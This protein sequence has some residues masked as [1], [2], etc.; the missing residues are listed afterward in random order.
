MSITVNIV[1]PEWVATPREPN[2]A[3]EPRTQDRWD[4]GDASPSN[5]DGEEAN[6]IRACFGQEYLAAGLA[7]DPQDGA[8]QPDPSL[9]DQGDVPS[10]GGQVDP[11]L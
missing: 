10:E 6:A 1:Q 2:D 11:S 5:K 3:H 4:H 8:A 9:L 7:D